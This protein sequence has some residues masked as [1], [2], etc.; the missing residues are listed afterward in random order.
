[1]KKILFILS[2]VFI[3][4]S[5]K[6][7]TEKEISEPDNKDR[8][9]DSISKQKQKIVV[10]SLKKTHKIKNP[11]GYKEV[12]YLGT[13]KKSTGDTL[14]YVFG[15]YSAVQAA[16]QIHGHSNIIYLNKKLKEI[17]SYDV[18]L[19]DQLPYKLNN[20][21]LYFKYIDEKTNKM[22][23]FENKVGTTPPNIMCVGPDDCN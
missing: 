17:K 12:N 11:H 14:Y 10:D 15:I 20:N 16:I 7:T 22:K 23:I 13:I 6:N 5:C 19:P 21:T 8:I 3:L 2:L 9:T 4:F 1:M 18:G